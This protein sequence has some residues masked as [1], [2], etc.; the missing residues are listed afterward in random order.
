MSWNEE[1]SRERVKSNDFKDYEI[2]VSDLSTSRDF[3]TLGTKEVR[4]V[5]GVHI[6][7]DI[8][9]FHEAVGD[10]GNDKQKQRKLV[11][12][13]SVLRKIQRDLLEHDDIG[14]IQRQSARIHSLN[15]KPYD[16]QAE[17]AKRAVIYAITYNSYVHDV[18]NDVF[19][20]VRNFE[21]AIG[22]AS[23]TTYVANIGRRGNR[24]LIS[25]GSAANLGAKVL[26]AGDTI[27]ITKDVYDN[28]PKCLQGHFKKAGIISAAQAYQ[29]TSLRWAQQPE[30]ADELDIQFDEEKWKQKTEEYRDVLAL[31]DINITDATTLIDVSQLTEK[32]CKRTSSVALFVDLDGFTKY[33]QQAEND[34]TVISLIR[35]FH[36]IRSEF[37]AVVESD[38]DG[39]VLQHQGDGLFG[40]VHMPCG[41]SRFDKRCQDAVDVA[42]GLQSSMDHVLNEHLLDREDIHV[43]VGM[44]VGDVLVSRLGKKGNRIVIAFGIAVTRAEKL[45]Q[46]SAAQQIRQTEPIYDELDDD[47]KEEFK[48]HG[49]SFVA[50]RLTFRRLDE[51]NE[52]Q[53]AENNSL[54]ALVEDNRIVIATSSQTDNRNWQSSKPWMSE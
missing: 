52:E 8:P 1:R 54:A 34:D 11:R 47:I 2:N 43:A 37:H 36:M 5:N 4:R 30:L 14:D 18:F 13:A 32:N 7:A 23:G 10:T 39:L 53:A 42:I 31:S 33:V 22:A 21:S 49:D 40:I 51:I 28:L 24:E 9:N 27:T 26:S 44:D 20:D 17:R 25:L 12:A 15:Y 6:Y 35:Q 19:S 3:R 38:Y 48:K 41:S 46:Q 16:D 50:K 45:Q 29:A